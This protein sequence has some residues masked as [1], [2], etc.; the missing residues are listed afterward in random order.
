MVPWG[1]HYLEGPEE[2]SK[3]KAYI[4]RQKNVLEFKQKIMQARHDK[5]TNTAFKTISTIFT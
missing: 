2:E 1:K 4:Y 3:G 5:F